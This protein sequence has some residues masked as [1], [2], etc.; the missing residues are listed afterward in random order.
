VTSIVMICLETWS[1]ID[2]TMERKY[3]AT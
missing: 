3:T 2:L 1:E